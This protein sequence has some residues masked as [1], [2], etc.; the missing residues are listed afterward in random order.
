MHTTHLS[1]A[2]A[3]AQEPVQNFLSSLLEFERHARRIRRMSMQSF[4]DTLATTNSDFANGEELVR[5]IGE[6]THTMDLIRR[7]IAK[8][9]AVEVTALDGADADQLPAVL[10]GAALIS[11]REMT[12]RLGW[13]RQALSKALTAQRVFFVELRGLRY[14]PSFFTEPRYQRRQL[15]AVSKLLGALSGGAKL[16]F[17]TTPKGSLAGKTPLDA[18]ADGQ[19]AAVRIAA[20]GFAQR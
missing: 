1:V 13:T 10:E 8:A 20:Q 2:S 7:G 16:Q 12:E 19:Y 6:L 11:P 4:V 15:E 17:F 18:L 9:S 14:F 3:G 5:H